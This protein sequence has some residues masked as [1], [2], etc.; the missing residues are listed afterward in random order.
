[1]LLP[2]APDDEY[3]GRHHCQLSALPNW[4]LVTVGVLALTVAGCRAL[5]DAEI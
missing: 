5:F 2:D 1:L 4:V 3:D